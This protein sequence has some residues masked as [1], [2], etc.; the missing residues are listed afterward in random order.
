MAVH[1]KLLLA[2]II[3]VVVVVLVSF[4]LSAVSSLDDPPIHLYKHN[5]S[6][7]SDK[8][9]H[10]V[11]P[12]AWTFS[13]WGLIY[14]WQAL[15]L[16]FAIVNVF[17]KV[18]DIPAYINPVILQPS[19]FF[20]YAFNYCLTTAWS[21]VFDREILEAS[22]GILVVV[23]FT[24][25]FCLFVAYKKLAE[26]NQI[27]SKQGRHIEIWLHRIFVHNG[28]GI[29]AA[30][31][32]IAALLTLTT[33]LIYRC[34]VDYETAGTISLGVL[35]AEFAIFVGTDLFL[36][37]RFSR[38]TLTPYLVV[39]YALG[40]VLS[41]NWNSQKTNSIFSAAL[42]GIGLAAIV[43]KLIMMFMRHCRKSKSEDLIKSSSVEP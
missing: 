12:A 27:L 25:Y 40:G 21:F 11:K 18:D 35:S 9:H 20:V 19:L 1:N 26:H 5:M 6:Y 38:Y 34:D 28:L 33:L 31:T 32:T 15:W 29:Y 37:D 8:Y 23:P 42:L 41:E 17:R 14:F 43:L 16:I 3:T 24:L 30:W 10:G 4:G 39:P 13:I 2:S 36:F 22:F 7:L